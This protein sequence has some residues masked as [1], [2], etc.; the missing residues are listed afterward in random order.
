MVASS[1]TYQWDAGNRLKS[2][3]NGS[4]GSYG[5][6]GNGKWVRKTESGTTTYYV[7]SSELGSV[8]EV[9]SGGVQRAYVMNGGSVVAQL[10]PNGQFYWLHLDHPG[11]GRKMT[12]STGA[13]TYRAEF[14]PYG[15]L[16][17]EW[18]SPTNLNTKKFT[19]Y[20][21]DAATN[22]DYA[23]ARMY[24][25]DWGRFTSPDPMGLGAARLNSP[26]SFNR[27]AY[28]EN[29]PVN[30][31]DTNGH[32]LASWVK[33]F[34]GWVSSVGSGDYA[35]PGGIPMP[36]ALGHPISSTYD[37]YEPTLYDGG[38]HHALDISEKDI[39]EWLD[40][41][42][43]KN[44]CADVLKSIGIEAGNKDLLKG[45]KIL[46]LSNSTLSGLLKDKKLSELG[47]P[48]GKSGE[49]PTLLDWNNGLGNLAL[50]IPKITNFGPAAPGFIF[51]AF[52]SKQD[53]TPKGLTIAH[54]LIHI[55]TNGADHAQLIKDFKIP[56]KGK[57]DDELAQNNAV[58]DWLKGECKSSP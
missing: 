38:S 6:D 52:F 45:Y 46:D 27:Y 29:N 25:S 58:N 12:D 47:V 20:E 13:M 53:D 2:M 40:K 28:V 35:S 39:L 43:E 1:T 17:Y 30:Y 50:G 15:K 36:S 31:V 32:N 19:G 42:L 18:S 48:K 49:D 22:L 8:M 37:D 24:A 34:W 9:T 21:R 41:W 11:S 54:E 23:Q 33:K 10:N 57:D 7:I 26:K 3:D 56:Y 16:L 51:S 4:L 44:P 14:D 5:Y 55:R